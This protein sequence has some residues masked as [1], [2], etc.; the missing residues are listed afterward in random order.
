MPFK[1]KEEERPPDVT[2]SKIDSGVWVAV[3][4][5]VGLRGVRI[6]KD[7]V[8]MLKAYYGEVDEGGK[9]LH[10]KGEIE[11]VFNPK[12]LR[13]KEIRTPEPY[14]EFNEKD[15]LVQISV[16]AIVD[17]EVRFIHMMFDLDE[18]SRQIKELLGGYKQLKNDFEKITGFKPKL[19]WWQ[20][21]PYLK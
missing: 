18:Q 8:S 21:L 6:T 2:L 5:G 7:E 16:R 13:V 11:V 4:E 3:K 19:S 12:T 9:L 14:H 20:N 1:L 15:K 10:Y 17:G